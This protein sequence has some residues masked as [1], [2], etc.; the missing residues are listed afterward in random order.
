LNLIRNY[1]ILGLACLVIFST[2]RMSAPLMEFMIFHDNYIFECQVIQHHNTECAG[3]CILKHELA[4]QGHKKADLPDPVLQKHLKIIDL[5]TVSALQIPL[6]FNIP[7][8]LISFYSHSLVDC[9]SETEIPP[10]RFSI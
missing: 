7:I 10:P 5:N 6:Y 8:P 4:E 3:F 1:L 2:V 9:S